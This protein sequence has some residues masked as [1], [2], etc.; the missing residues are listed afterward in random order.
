MLRFSFNRFLST[1]INREAIKAEI[2]PKDAVHA[3]F[4]SGTI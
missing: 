1:E 3:Q 2:H 4:N